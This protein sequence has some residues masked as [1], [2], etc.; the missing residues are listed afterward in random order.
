MF[1][2]S[3]TKEGTTQKTVIIS[4]YKPDAVVKNVIDDVVVEFFDNNSSVPIPVP[5]LEHI[6][7]Y[8]DLFDPIFDCKKL[9][10]ALVE[11]IKKFGDLNGLKKEINK[12]TSEIY[13]HIEASEGYKKYFLKT[14]PSIVIPDCVM[15]YNIY[16]PTN[17]NKWFVSIDIKSA[18]FRVL[19]N[20]CGD[21]FTDVNEFSEFV[22]KFTESEFIKQCK[23]IR[24]VIFGRTGQCKKINKMALI[25]VDKVAK[26][27]ETTEYIK[28]MKKVMCSADEIVYEIDDYMIGQ[29]NELKKNVED[30]MPNFFHV[31]MFKLVQI[32]GKPFYMKE[33]VGGKLDLKQVP[34][35][36]ACQAVKK[37]FNKEIVE[38][39][40]KFV[41]E[42]YIATYDKCV[43]A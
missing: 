13:H 32:G 2:R 11:D 39:D 35:K 9:Y 8:L 22:A 14:D 34:K 40:M 42:G 27:I 38:M 18:N 12:V 31:R 16:N 20:I 7:Y 5:K 4:K 10:N 15:N 21:I 17:N 43:F 23:M 29:Y 19:K 33:L 36:F 41:D 3:V 24:E 30:L 28:H 37:Y 25:F 6:N 26:F 1:S